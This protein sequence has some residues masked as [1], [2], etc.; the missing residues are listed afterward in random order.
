MG[1]RNKPEYL[2]RSHCST[3][4]AKYIDHGGKP[5]HEKMKLST[6]LGRRRHA[7]RLFVTKSLKEGAM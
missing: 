3:N 7:C 1:R 5:I 4:M 2:L 6:A